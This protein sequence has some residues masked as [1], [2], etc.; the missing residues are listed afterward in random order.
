V[1]VLM[2]ALDVLLLAAAIGA[3]P[4]LARGTAALQVTFKSG[5]DLVSFAVT[6]V[7]KKG[8][9]VEGLTRDDFEVLEDGQKQTLRLFLAP[10][11]DAEAA[12]PLHLGVLF[13]L[14][15]SMDEDMKMA[16][17]AAIRFLN[18]FSDAVD[19]TIVDFDIEVRVARYGQAEFPR[20]VERLRNRKAEGYT[21]L[22][23]ALGVYLDGASGQEGRKV[24]IVYSDGGDNSSNIGFGDVITLLRASDVSVYT[25]GFLEHQPSSARIGQR[26]HLM[27]ISEATG[28]QAFFP[29]T[30]KEIDE[31]YQ[32][33]ESEIRAQYVLGYLS[34]NTQA[35]G[36]WRKVEIKV[37][38]PA[39]K[40]TRVRT[41]R[42]YFAPY[43]PSVPPP[44]PAR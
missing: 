15:G 13:D 20:L 5:V 23:D 34:S 17:T 39:S 40:D 37:T 42:G 25:I 12:P 36:R 21:A 24:L 35:D 18:T 9:L 1:K 33:I 2:A 30:V 10:P 38:R 19:M 27:E 14:S 28:G 44:G 32:K 7:G 3:T 29:T 8:E 26:Q 11:F 6:V 41:R 31:A 43:K 4:H 22:W 16:R